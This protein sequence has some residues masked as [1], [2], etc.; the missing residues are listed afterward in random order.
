MADQEMPV[1]GKESV[2]SIIR[3]ALEAGYNDA[4][5][6]SR[7]QAIAA[8]IVLLREQEKKGMEKYGRSLQTWN[9]RDPILDAM[10]EEIDRWAYL[11]QARMELADA[12]KE[13]A[14]LKAQKHDWRDVAKASEI[15]EGRDFI[16]H[17]SLLAA[18]K[19]KYDYLVAG[20]QA[21]GIMVKP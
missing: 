1:T 3:H 18:T 8:A 10:Q 20:L 13:L 2:M 4:R 14:E 6:E 15:P 16:E 9:G 21:C 12:K 19:R 17:M 5:D 7:R 11:V